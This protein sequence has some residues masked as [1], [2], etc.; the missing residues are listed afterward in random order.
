L[1]FGFVR[2]Y[3][4]LGD[5]LAAMRTVVPA[6]GARL[7]V[8]G[9]VWGSAQPYLDQVHEL[10]LEAHVT[11]VNRYVPNDEAAAYMA[12]ADVAVL[13]YRHATGSGVT[14]FAHSFG[15]PVI[16][17]RTGNLGEAIEDG[18]TGFLVTP[19]DVSG[20]AGAIIRFFQEGWASRF[21]AAIDQQHD[22]FSWENIARL[23][24]S[25]P[26]AGVLQRK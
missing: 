23:V 11:F 10:G 15:V 22:R 16:A 1:F 18:V 19:G 13:P 9:E 21:Q 8:V 6:C 7:L 20:L 2:P 14:Q 3:K 25:W 24:E 17:T 4:G 5:L 12:A 26:A